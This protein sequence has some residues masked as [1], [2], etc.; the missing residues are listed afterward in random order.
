MA[1]AKPEGEVLERVTQKLHDGQCLVCDA[2]PPRPRRGL[3]P[4]C[5]R[6]F[7]IAK[8][9][10]PKRAQAEWEAGLIRAGKVLAPNQ[11]SS[12]MRPNPFVEA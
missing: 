11:V 3:C 10:V 6:L 7:R 4:K 2:K 1:F 9:R 12:I 5:E 8:S